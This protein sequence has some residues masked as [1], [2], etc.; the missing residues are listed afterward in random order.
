MEH[1]DFFQMRDM[2][3]N[4]GG[5]RH[6]VKGLSISPKKSDHEVIRVF[7]IHL[8]SWNMGSYFFMMPW[9]KGRFLFEIISF[10]LSLL[11]KLL[12]AGGCQAL[13]IKLLGS[14]IILPNPPSNAI[15][16]L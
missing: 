7:Q 14:V 9:K 11:T 1:P 12:G 4:E 13:L 15:A 5:I 3:S 10:K 6:D 16:I 8:W 2:H